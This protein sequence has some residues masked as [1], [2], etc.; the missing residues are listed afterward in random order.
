MSM[1]DDF[2]RSLQRPLF[3][4]TR[5]FGPQWTLLPSFAKLPSAFK[6][7]PHPIHT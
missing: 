4:F 3:G 1:N 6:P 2:Y 5:I 7:H